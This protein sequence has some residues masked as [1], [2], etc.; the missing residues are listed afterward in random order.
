MAAAHHQVVMAKELTPVE[1]DERE[2]YARLRETPLRGD[3]QHSGARWMLEKEMRTDGGP[4]GGILADEVGMGKT[5][6]TLGVVFSRLKPRTLIVTPVATTYQWRREIVDKF[7]QL[8]DHVTHVMNNHTPHT[9]GEY[10]REV[11]VVITSYEN[12]RTNPPWI[13]NTR[14]DRVVLDEGHVTRN[15]NTQVNQAMRHLNM[16]VCWILTATPIHNDLSDLVSLLRTCR[17]LL[18]PQASEGAALSEAETKK[19]TKRRK[20]K[21]ASTTMMSA[22]DYDRLR[23]LQAEFMLRRTVDREHVNNPYLRLKPL[24]VTVVSVDWRSAYERE[25]YETLKNVVDAGGLRDDDDGGVM[26]V[27]S[28][29][30]MRQLCVSFRVLTESIR[31]KTSSAAEGNNT[32][33]DRTPLSLSREELEGYSEGGGEEE[34]EE[35]ESIR[36]DAEARAL[37]CFVRRRGASASAA[38]TP[39]KKKQKKDVTRDIINARIAFAS[40]FEHRKEDEDRTKE[41]DQDE[42]K[43]ED[44]EEDR[45]GEEEGQENPTRKEEEEEKKKEKRKADRLRRH[46]S[47][48]LVCGVIPVSIF[49]DPRAFTDSQS[50]RAAIEAA[51]P[52]KSRMAVK[53]EVAG[54]PVSP[55][56]GEG[57]LPLVAVYKHVTA[58]YKDLRALPR[59]SSKMLR[60]QEILRANF[61]DPATRDDKVIVFTTFMAEMQEVCKDLHAMGLGF[62][63]ISGNMNTLQRDQS[64]HS[65][66]TLPGIKVMVAQINCTSTGINLQCAN[67]AV[68]TSPTWNPCIEEQA[69]GRIHRQ[70][71]TKPVRV[72]RME[73][74]DTIESHCIERQHD[75]TMIIDNYVT[76]GGSRTDTRENGRRSPQQ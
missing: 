58:K 37:S 40:H 65:F 17:V 74:R 60:L 76:C 29:V 13:R 31:K 21:A 63:R 2:V 44:R 51:D 49:H 26:T 52:E 61:E 25:L 18:P 23:K 69:I 7:P 71:Q 10:W 3:H 53:K 20:K 68:I 75:K 9:R 5:F 38:A 64:L 43:E 46:R 14:W 62:T 48:N 6:V 47:K 72:Y 12:L 55:L 28:I 56:D 36:E 8:R 32:T 30:Y 59:S 67:V 35:E 11:E 45:A 42:K 39:A 41:D 57:G 19:G 22:Q 54:I 1:D 15:D 33:R 27:Q 4:K 50:V 34:E 24:T 66:T 16:D 70:G 73:M